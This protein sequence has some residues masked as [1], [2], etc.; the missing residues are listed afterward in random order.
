MKKIKGD[1]KQVMKMNT[2][3]VFMDLNIFLSAL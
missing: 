1:V 2:A 3:T